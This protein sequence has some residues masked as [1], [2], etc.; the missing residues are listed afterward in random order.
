MNIFECE[1]KAQEIGF[2]R[3]KFIAVFP[4]G[5]VECRWGD[6]YMGVVFINKEGLRDGFIMTR[7]ID[8]AY[9]GLECS[10]PYL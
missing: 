4:C 5:P 6:A 2:D 8:K 3:A 1:R 10:E 9:P 7:D